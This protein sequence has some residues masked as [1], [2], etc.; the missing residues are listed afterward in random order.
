MAQRFNAY[1]FQVL[2]YHV[3]LLNIYGIEIREM[4]LGIGE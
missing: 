2:E 1:E 3:P 4:F